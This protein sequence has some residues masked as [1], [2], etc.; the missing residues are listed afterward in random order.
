MQQLVAHLTQQIEQEDSAEPLTGI[1]QGQL[2]TCWAGVQEATAA[3]QQESAVFSSD[4]DFSEHSTEELSAML[5]DIREASR[6]LSVVLAMEPARFQ[7]DT[8]VANDLQALELLG[9]YC[10]PE[11]TH[12]LKVPELVRVLQLQTESTCPRGGAPEQCPYRHRATTVPLTG[13]FSPGETAEATLRKLY[14]HFAELADYCRVK[15]EDRKAAS[16]QHPKKQ[17]AVRKLRAAVTDLVPRIR[18]HVLR[19]GI[20]KG[21][22]LSASSGR[23]GPLTKLFAYSTVEDAHRNVEDCRDRVLQ[24]LAVRR[25]RAKMADDPVLCRADAHNAA[26]SKTTV[27]YHRS[28]MRV[29]DH[30]AGVLLVEHEKRVES[31][32]RQ[33][34]AQIHSCCTLTPSCVPLALSAKEVPGQRNPSAK[35]WQNQAPPS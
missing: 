25:L 10:D 1:T 35:H 5:P 4:A 9:S 6:A 18:S 26:R 34:A 19:V 24:E 29:L 33:Y 27:L 8:L 22:P 16:T 7:E 20:A 21:Q 15:A 11:I 13:D 28:C 32:F 23:I 17:N 12:A 14:T 30:L 2:N 3:F 31:L